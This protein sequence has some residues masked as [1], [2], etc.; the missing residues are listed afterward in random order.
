MEIRQEIAQ[1]VET[2][3]QELL[4]EVLAYLRQVEKTS[5]DKLRLSSNLQSIL[6]EDREVLEKLAK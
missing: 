2:L 1:L 3:P 5:Q 4:G 6:L